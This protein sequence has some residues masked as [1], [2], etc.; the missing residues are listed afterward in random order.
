V[1]TTPD[2]HPEAR[3][4]IRSAYE[5]Y[6]ERNVEKADEFLGRF[7]TLID[8]A[9]DYPDIGSPYLYHTRRLLLRSFPFIIVYQHQRETL[10]VVA[11]AHTSRRPGYWR[12]RLD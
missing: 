12:D 8:M 6:L 3:D 4:E 10:W 2:Y 5:W 11:L 1:A 7:L 9:V